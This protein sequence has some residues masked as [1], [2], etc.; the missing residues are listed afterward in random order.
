MLR[1][2]RH[3]V[4]E[5]VGGVGAE[6]RGGDLRLGKVG[7]QHLDVVDAVIDHA[8]R[9]RGEAA[10]AA[11][12]VLRRRLQHQ[13]RGAL[14]LRRERRAKRGITGTDDDYVVLFHLPSSAYAREQPASSISTPLSSPRKRGPMV[15]HT[16]R[17]GSPLSRGRQGRWLLL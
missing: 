3:V 8:D 7:D 4:K 17:D 9:A 15:P 6:I 2:A 5:L 10:V 1:H 13:H 11:G 14:L 12:F 16:R